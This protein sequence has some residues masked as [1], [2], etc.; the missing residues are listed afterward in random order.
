MGIISLFAAKGWKSTLMIV[1]PFDDVILLLEIHWKTWYNTQAW[2]YLFLKK[3]SMSEKR[4]DSKGR[5]LRTGENQRADGKYEYKYVEA[6]GVRRSLYSWRLVSSDKM[7]PKKR[8]CEVLRD[9][10]AKVLRDM[11][12]GINSFAAARMTLNDFWKCYIP[13]KYELKASTQTNYKYMYAKCI[14]ENI[15]MRDIVSVRSAT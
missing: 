6:K 9:M 4:R 8:A 2:P 7:P 11:Q 5:L 1:I 15:G 3:V 13:T 12:D 14:K 10:K